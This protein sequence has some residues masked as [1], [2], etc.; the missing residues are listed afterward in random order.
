MSIP[1]RIPMLAVTGSSAI[2]PHNHRLCSKPQQSVRLMG[3]DD[4]GTITIF[5]SLCDG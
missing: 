2:E 1:G 5:G 4:R 3:S